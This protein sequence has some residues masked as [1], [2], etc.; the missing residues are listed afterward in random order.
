[1]EHNEEGCSYTWSEV[2]LKTCEAAAQLR[3]IGKVTVRETTLKKIGIKQVKYG[4]LDKHFEVKRFALLEMI[5]VV[6]P[7][8]WSL[9]MKTAMTVAYNHLVEAIKEEMNS[10]P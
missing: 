1:M 9:E 7:P 5:K 3:T 10:L 4:V 8:I 6:V 2:L